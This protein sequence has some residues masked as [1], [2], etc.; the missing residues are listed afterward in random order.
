VAETGYFQRFMIG[1]I[2]VGALIS[3]F[4]L[5]MAGFSGEY[6]GNYDNTSLE[7]YD[8]LEEVNRDVE[9]VREKTNIEEKSGVL[10]VI[11]G[12]FSSGYVALK[13]AVGSIDLLVGTGGMM[14]KGMDDAGLG[15]VGSILLSAF[16]ALI[17]VSVAIVVL[18]KVIFKVNP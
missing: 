18:F 17:I 4:T 11:G 10:D 14:D 15:R 13:S 7:Y 1:V 8:K 2:L 16:S 12:Y 3:I 9:S 5:N 6:S